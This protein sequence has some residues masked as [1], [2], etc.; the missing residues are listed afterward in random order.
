VFNQ[1]DDKSEKLDG[2]NPSNHAKASV[3][4]GSKS[5]KTG[6]SFFVKI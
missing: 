1:S 3:V 2:S 4:S 6:I 5:A